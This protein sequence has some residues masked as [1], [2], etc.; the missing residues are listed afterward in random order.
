MRAL[1]LV[2]TTTFA[3]AAADGIVSRGQPSIPVRVGT[4]DLTI[5]G[6]DESRDQYIFQAISGLAFDPA[7]RMIVTDL[8]EN[9]VRVFQTNGTFAFQAGRRGA[10]PGEYSEP[11]GAAFSRDG[12]LWVQDESNRR[13]NAYT[14]GAT[15]ATPTLSVRYDFDRPMVNRLQ[16]MA[17]D[18]SGRITGIGSIIGATPAD[19]RGARFTLDRSGGGVRV[20][21]IRPAPADSL[22]DL[23]IT[24]QHSEG[25][26]TSTTT[27]YYFPVFG[28]EFVFTQSSTG[29]TARAITSRYDI[30][31]SDSRGKLLR[32]IRRDVVGPPLSAREKKV[33]QDRIDSF[34][35]MTK[36][37]PSQLPG[38]PQRK[39]PI[40]GMAFDQMNRLWVERS[41]PDGAPR[42][43]DLYD[44]TGNQ[45]A[46]MRW[47]ANV[48]LLGVPTV[49]VHASHAL[50]V[51]TDSLGTQRVVR[52]QFK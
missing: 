24:S 17:F 47:P 50:G 35:S 8:K 25:G 13:F 44:A 52:L 43:A 15:S 2:A 10:G 49:A 9:A 21:T 51:G 11:I 34:V 5:G 36:S 37:S 18:E 22:G 16:P 20:D 30:A 28:P 26:K 42:E 41:V 14:L 4:P 3:L 32:T 46:V 19:R 48:R 31:L 45:I 29:A 38:V 27:H 39:V 40:Q 1:V 12:L 7:G 23:Q 6:E 33:A